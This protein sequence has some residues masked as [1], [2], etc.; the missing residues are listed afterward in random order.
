MNSVWFFPAA[1]GSFLTIW[2]IQ[3]DYP[4]LPP[5]P[6]AA[7]RH[8]SKNL[9][10]WICSVSSLLTNRAFIIICIYLGG[11]L[12]LLNTIQTKALQILCARGY[13]VQFSGI[14][15]AIIGICA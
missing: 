1:L 15:V 2:K 5:S 8:K 11:S 9:R 14:A 4:K 13:T 12:G 6:S 7:D 10:E 3:S